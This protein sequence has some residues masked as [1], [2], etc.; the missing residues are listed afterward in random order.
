MW[1]RNKALEEYRRELREQ[2]IERKIEREIERESTIRGLHA[3]IR[4]LEAERDRLKSKYEMAR[5]QV[6]EMEQENMGRFLESKGITETP[7]HRPK[8]L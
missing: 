5:R 8:G 6:R 7:V 1:F 3:E 4:V 2:E